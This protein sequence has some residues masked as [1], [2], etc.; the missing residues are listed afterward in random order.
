MRLQRHTSALA[1]ALICQALAPAAQAEVTVRMETSLGNIDIELYD[2]AAPVTVENFLN[3]VRRGRY[4]GSFI[5]RSEPGFVIQGGGYYIYNGFYLHVPA[6]PPIVNEFDPSRSNVRGTIAMA[7]L[8]N[9]PDSATSEWFFNLTDNSANLDSQ[10]GGF[11]VFGEVINDGMNVVDA[12]ANLDIWNMSFLSPIYGGSFNSM[13]LIDFTQGD[14]FD[15]NRHLVFVN[16]VREILNVQGNQALLVDTNDN[17]VGLTAVQPATLANVRAISNPSS[18]NTPTG[19]TFREGFFTFEVND[20]TP[21]GSIM[22]AMELPSDYRPNTYYMYGPTPD[23]TAPHWYEFKYDGQTGAEFFNNNF[24]V[25]HF[26]DGQRGDSDLTANG[27]IQ[28]P[29]APG[30]TTVTTTSSSGG[31]GCTLNTASRPGDRMDFWALL[32]GL[33]GYTATRRRVTNIR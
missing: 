30:V 22:V 32:F 10:N 7:K 31:G 19:V 4:N 11:T 9:N 12:I 16:R 17:L 24:V 29:G 1:T 20:V 2:E 23:N 8:G 21:G 15:A 14:T 13:P 5:H 6:D 26:V 27:S 33:I 3:Y 28:D 18:S 25:L